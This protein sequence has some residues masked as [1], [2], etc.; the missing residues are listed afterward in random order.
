MSKQ[1]ELTAASGHAHHPQKNMAASDKN[2]LV[3]FWNRNPTGRKEIMQTDSPTLNYR[4][5][6]MQQILHYARPYIDYSETHYASGRA[7]YPLTPKIYG[8]KEEL[9]LL[10]F[11]GTGLYEQISHDLPEDCTR[12]WLTHVCPET[13][14]EHA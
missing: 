11:I 14:G 8:K 4:L 9:V 7:L 10:G 1:I 12:N 2:L 3:K 6:R 13:K 5:W